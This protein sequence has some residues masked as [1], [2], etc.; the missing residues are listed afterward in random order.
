[1]LDYCIQDTEVTLKSL[2]NLLKRRMNDYSRLLVPKKND[3]LTHEEVP[4]KKLLIFSSHSL[5]KS[6]AVCLKAVRLKTHCYE[7]VGKVWR[8]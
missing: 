7:D 4:K 8:P 1:M 6:T 2:G 3:P 5:M